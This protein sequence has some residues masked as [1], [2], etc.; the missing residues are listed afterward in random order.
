VLQ[1]VANE[2]IVVDTKVSNVCEDVS[3]E[4][5]K[6][7]PWYMSGGTQWPLP[8]AKSPKSGRRMALLWPEEDPGSDRITNQLMFV[9]PSSPAGGLTGQRLKMILFYYGLGRHIRLK[10]G[11]DMFTDDRC[12]VDTCTITLDQN[13]AAEADAIVYYGGFSHP[14]H[15]RPPRQVRGLHILCSR[16]STECRDQVVSPAL[17]FGVRVFE[18]CYEVEV[19]FIFRTILYENKAIELPECC[20]CIL[21]FPYQFIIHVITNVKN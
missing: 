19:F 18:I 3:Y 20:D 8:A 4:D 16:G 1:F 5:E 21:P 14:G 2:R 17:S 6:C 12:P 10:P 13:Q 15:S 7:R 11:R 9:P